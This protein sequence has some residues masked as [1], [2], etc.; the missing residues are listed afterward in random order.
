MYYNN[1]NLK[2]PQEMGHIVLL[3]FFICIIYAEL[4]QAVFFKALKSI[5]IQQSWIRNS[6]HAI[7]LIIPSVSFPLTH[8]IRMFNTLE[9]F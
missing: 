3:E 7:S 9:N 2:I 1:A 8:Y 4:L 6:A 5:D